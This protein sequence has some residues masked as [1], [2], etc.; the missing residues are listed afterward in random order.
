MLP[1]SGLAE[2]KSRSMMM[3]PCGAPSVGAIPGFCDRGGSP[4]AQRRSKAVRRAKRLIRKSLLQGSAY[5]RRDRLLARLRNAR[6]GSGTR[7]A[8][9]SLLRGATVTAEKSA[10]ENMSAKCSI[11]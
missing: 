3:K 4:C 9:S 7:A 2:S 5:P 8:A 1:R 10:G 11:S 6:P